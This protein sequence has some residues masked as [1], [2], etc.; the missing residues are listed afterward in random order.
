MH[1]N[2]NNA[3]PPTSSN[4]IQPPHASR[5]VTVM[6]LPEA[7]DVFFNYQGYNCKWVMCRMKCNVITGKKLDDGDLKFT[8]W[9]DLV[10]ANDDYDG[11]IDFIVSLPSIW[12]PR[13]V[14]IFMNER[15]IKYQGLHVLNGIARL[16]ISNIFREYAD[17]S[18]EYLFHHC[19]NSVS[20]MNIQGGSIQR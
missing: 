14:M 3:P 1:N 12:T 18:D 9:G 6:E 10:E 19:F 7:V 17:R 16:D 2:S 8:F 5:N 20:N 13:M 11:S 15:I 4:R